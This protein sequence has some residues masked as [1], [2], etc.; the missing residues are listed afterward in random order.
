M[1]NRHGHSLKLMLSIA[2]LCV[3]TSCKAESTDNGGAGAS[4]AAAGM[5]ATG[6]VGATT[7]GV[8]A[9]T[10]GVGGT[11]GTTGG[12]GGMTGGTSGASATTGGVGGTAGVSA[13]GGVGGMTGGASGMTGGM[14][15]GASGMTG[16]SGGAAGSTPDA[17]GDDD[18][19]FTD[20][21]SI[22]EAK[23]GGGDFGCHVMGSSGEL[24]MHDQAS[25]YT[26]LVGVDSSECNGTRVVA[27]DADASLIIKALEGTACVDQMPR[28]R[29]PLSEDEIATIRSWI[30][31]G[32]LNN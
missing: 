14:T 20:V 9:T 25:A 17:G 12:V 29:D 23:C 26:N 21:F 3:V 10:G 18:A 4:G 1:L 28:G 11:A 27:G 30:E 7:G 13:T 16:G 32:A 24:E 31:A 6:G 5:T 8:G 15:G 2:A 19:T 22:I